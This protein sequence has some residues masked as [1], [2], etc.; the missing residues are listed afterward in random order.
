LNSQLSACPIA[1]PP[2]AGPGADGRPAAL[3]D[4]PGERPLADARAGG[5]ARRRAGPLGRLPDPARGRP[6][7]TGVVDEAEQESPGRRVSLGRETSSSSPGLPAPGLRTCSFQHNNRPMLGTGLG[8]DDRFGPAQHSYRSDAAARGSSDRPAHPGSQPEE[9]FS[10]AAAVHLGAGPRV[11]LPL[12][13]TP[14]A[15][16]PIMISGGGKCLENRAV[17]SPW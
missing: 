15:L 6:R 2:A 12:A 10:I 14:A 8:A 9:R 16:A 13:V 3:T 17:T 11:F 4:S 5:D 1:G 7:G